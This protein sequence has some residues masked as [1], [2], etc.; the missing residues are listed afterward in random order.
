MKNQKN[1]KREKTSGGYAF[2]M[3]MFGVSSEF[4]HEPAYLSYQ[5]ATTRA[6]ASQKKLGWSPREPHTPLAKEM[7]VCVQAFLPKDLASELQLFCAIG[8]SLDIHHGVDGFFLTDEF[9]VTMDISCREKKAHEIKADILVMRRDTGRR[10]WRVS[11]D[12]ADR[13]SGV[14]R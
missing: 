7:F 8:T 1:T 11:R 4:V 2:E 12:I 10:L 6:I 9:C 5:E 13:I 3:D 14:T